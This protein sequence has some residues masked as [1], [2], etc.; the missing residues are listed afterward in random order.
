MFSNFV[1]KSRQEH[2]Q[3][4]RLVKIVSMLLTLSHKS[5]SCNHRISSTISLVLG[6]NLIVKEKVNSLKNNYFTFI[7]PSQLP[8][9]GQCYLRDHIF[10]FPETFHAVPKLEG[11]PVTFLQTGN[12]KQHQLLKQKTNGIQNKR[13]L[14]TTGF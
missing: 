5:S 8:Y 6:I 1:K 7:V 4:Q 2:T 3:G 14:N 10:L 9:L 12:L 13:W 11:W